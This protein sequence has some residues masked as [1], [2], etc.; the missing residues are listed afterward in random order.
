MPKFDKDDVNQ[1]SPNP[2]Q[3]QKPTPAHK[4]A[5]AKSSVDEAAE[6]AKHD[7]EDRRRQMGEGKDMRTDQEKS[8]DNAQ[9]YNKQ[10]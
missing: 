1:P 6:Q 9:N 4:P 7:D 5:P 3:P 10:S 8:R 2:P